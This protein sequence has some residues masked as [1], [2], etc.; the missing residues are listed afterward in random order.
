ML[1]LMPQ[2]ALMHEAELNIMA[3]KFNSEIARNQQ[4]SHD[5]HELQIKLKEQCDYSLA[6]E[7]YHELSMKIS[8]LELTLTKQRDMSIQAKNGILYRKN[9]LV[10]REQKLAEL[11]TNLNNHKEKLTA[12]WKKIE[13]INNIY[14]IIGNECTCIRYYPKI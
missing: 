4:M 9:E 5:M 14:C 8:E 13:I 1:V 2:A 11:E 3:Q 12:K 10:L 7:E 6:L